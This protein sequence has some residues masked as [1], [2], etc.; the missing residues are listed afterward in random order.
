MQRSQF[1]SLLLLSGVPLAAQ[2]C[3]AVNFRTAS[4]QNIHM[5]GDV[6]GLVRQSD[7]S[8]TEYTYNINP[9]IAVLSKIPNI[10]RNFFG[11]GGHTPKTVVPPANWTFVGDPLL[12]TMARDPA[13]ARLGPG[14]QKVIGVCLTL[15]YSDQTVMETGIVDFSG[16]LLRPPPI[17]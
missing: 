12:G 2:T 6:M 5:N 3:P 1:L 16:A 11:C 8:L 7:G 13:G 9:P 17:R 4:S 10:Q 15:C 14:A